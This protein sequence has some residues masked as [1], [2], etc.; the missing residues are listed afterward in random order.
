MQTQA[1]WDH[2]IPYLFRPEDVTGLHI[3]SPHPGKPIVGSILTPRVQLH[4]YSSN[5]YTRNDL[6]YSNERCPI[7]VFQVVKM[8]YT[9]RPKYDPSLPSLIQADHPLQG[10]ERAHYRQ[11]KEQGVGVIARA[12]LGASGG[13]LSSVLPIQLKHNNFCYVALKITHLSGTITVIR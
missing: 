6:P 1:M 12:L 4:L 2:E 5:S 3:H 11:T 7:Q 8:L 13:E 9:L 10:A